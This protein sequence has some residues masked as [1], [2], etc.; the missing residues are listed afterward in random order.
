MTT[1][2]PRLHYMIGGGIAALAAATHLI[3]DAGVAAETIR[4][5]DDR[6]RP[7]GALDGTGDAQ[8]GFLTRGGRMFEPNFVNTLD[9]LSQIPAPDDPA[10]SVT[11][12]ILA[13]NDQVRAA[14]SC[15]L[16]AG[17]R[18]AE[19]DHLGLSAADVLALNR[20]I[21]MPE[22]ALGAGTIGACFERP[23][24]DSNFWIMW[25]TMFSFQ[26]WHSAVEMRRY[27]RRFMHLFPGFTRIKGILRTRY[28]QYDS[29]IAPLIDWLGA[30]GVRFD[31]GATVAGI[32]I[33]GD[34]SHRDV[35]GIALA[36]GSHIPVRAEDRVFLTLGSMTDGASYGSTDNAPPLAPGPTPS[37]DL[38]RAL[39]TRHPGFGNP[40]AFAG[41]IDKRAWTSFTV[42]MDRPEFRDWLEAF[43]GNATG[44]GGLVTIR[45]SG[46]LMSFVMFNQPHFR[47]QPEGSTVFWGYGLRGDRPGDFVPKP[48]WQA[49]G[50]EI[51]AELCWQLRLSPSQRQ[52]FDGARVLPCRMPYITSQFMPRS[53]GDRPRTQPAGA[54]NFALMGQFVELPRD[55]VFTV[56]YSVRSA[57]A[58]VQ[59]LTG[60]AAP[61]PMVRSDRDPRVLLRAAKVL[62]DL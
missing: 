52:W 28:N 56:E 1:P 9:L 43:T 57:R 53:P 12:D 26:P 51:I 22:R 33:E 6:P 61:L 2:A 13:F 21:L 8:W 11:A 34:E 24:F 23:F 3:R 41:D 32:E 16:I 48:M 17:G 44:T 35:T 45:D 20:L 58:A 54:G 4:I 62:L 38:W 49:T 55:T 40:G 50:E 42:T 46:W 14:S 18:R 29:V 15:R 27:L 30:R 39:A 5:L 31:S 36:D 37:W 10:I 7:G 47:A 19:M 25:S 59:A 60:Q